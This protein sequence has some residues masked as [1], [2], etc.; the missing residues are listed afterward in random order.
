MCYTA[1]AGGIDFE[2]LVDDTENFPDE[3]HKSGFMTHTGA[4][5]CGFRGRFIEY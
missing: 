5:I 2:E 1:N 3:A 4:V